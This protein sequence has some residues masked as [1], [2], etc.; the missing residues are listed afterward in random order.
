MCLAQKFIF[1]FR[2]RFLVKYRIP[3][4]N[5]QYPRRPTQGGTVPLFVEQYPKN[6]EQLPKKVEQVPKAG[7]RTKLNILNLLGLYNQ[8]KI[9]LIVFKHNT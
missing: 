6:V 3:T 4:K 9:Y 2:F 5:R 8:A 1:T 7:Q